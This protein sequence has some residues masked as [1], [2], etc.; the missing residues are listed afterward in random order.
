MHQISKAQSK[1]GV[2]CILEPGI[3]VFLVATTINI[4]ISIIIISFI[5]I[6]YFPCVYN[7]Q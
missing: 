2:V 6:N 5:I 7:T 4:I 1:T 3:L